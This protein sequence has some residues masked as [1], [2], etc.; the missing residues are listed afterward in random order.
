MSDRHVRVISLIRELAATY[1]QQEANTDPMITITNAT[2]SPDYR[3]VTIFFTT[4]PEGRE[5]DAEIFL[6]RNASDLR[7]YIKKKSDLK[8][9]P[10]IDF[11]LDAG[12]RHRQ[13][14]DE[15]FK[16]INKPKD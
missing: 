7:N 6:K 13:Y 4:M 12:E 14:T 15:I 11:M 2:T 5:A 10:H 3:K 1:I 8:I 9:I 16:E